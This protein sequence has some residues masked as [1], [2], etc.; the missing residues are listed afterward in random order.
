MSLFRLRD[1]V[2]A[3]S[4]LI[5]AILS[6]G[7]SV[8]L[9]YAGASRGTAR[10]VVSFAVFGASLILLYAASTAYHA[11]RL[12]PRCTLALRKVDHMMIFVLIAG[13]YTPFCLLPLRGPWGWWLLGSVWGCAAA[14]MVVK[15]LW[16]NA[17]RWLSTGF[18]LLMGWLVLVAT[19]QLTQTVTARGLAWLASGGLFY[20]A[21]AILYMM[22]W[23][24]PWPG[25]VGFHEI[26]HL[27]V[28]AGSA[29]HFAAVLT[30]V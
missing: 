16:M 17:P 29:A 5:G 25:R 24:N 6:G 19:R 10:H 28:L 21:G 23:P 7:G 27:F 8:A 30:L 18:Y 3:V 4:H 2:S 12:S 15:L 26:W 20:T 14:G 11:L 1:P 13:S 22:K 9:L